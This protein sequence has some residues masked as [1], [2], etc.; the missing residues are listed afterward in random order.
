METAFCFPQSPGEGGIAGGPGDGQDVSAYVLAGT[1]V[2]PPEPQP[3][4]PTKVT[5]EGS[6][7]PSPPHIVGEEF[8]GLGVQPRQS[9]R[10]PI[11]SPSQAPPAPWSGLQWKIPRPHPHPECRQRGDPTLALE[12]ETRLGEGAGGSDPGWRGT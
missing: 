4:G 7:C 6:R 1:C 5:L 10:P 11:P 12:G 8:G 3:S 9:P 2:T